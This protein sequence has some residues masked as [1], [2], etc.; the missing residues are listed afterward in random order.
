[1]FDVFKCGEIEVLVVIDVV[2]CGFDIVELLVV[3]N[4]DLLF[5]VED[6][7]Y[8]IG[9]IGCVGVMGDVLLLCSLNECK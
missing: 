8:W 7:V 4:F 6:Y 1:M 9:C 5:S 3:I 2:V